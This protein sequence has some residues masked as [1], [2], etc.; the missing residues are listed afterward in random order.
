MSFILVAPLKHIVNWKRSSIFRVKETQIIR[1]PYNNHK[2]EKQIY[3]TEIAAIEPGYIDAISNKFYVSTVVFKGCPNHSLNA[4]FT[5]ENVIFEDCEG[6]FPWQTINTKNF[7]NVK[8]IY[9]PSYSDQRHVLTYILYLPK[10][11]SKITE[12]LT[13][14]IKQESNDKFSCLTNV[15]NP[16]V[17]ESV[18][19]I[20]IKD[21]E[22]RMNNL[23]QTMLH[24]KECIHKNSF[25]LKMNSRYSS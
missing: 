12:N 16:K 20:S 23:C 10:P 2:C 4:Q 8:N 21:F 22:E 3:S 9:L 17:R 24:P 1:D 18:K 15:N 19:K 5:A 13:I 11:D 7:P 14:F 25:T 6:L